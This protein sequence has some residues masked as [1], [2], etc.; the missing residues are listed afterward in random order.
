M[1]HRGL[2]LVDLLKIMM[3]ESPDL[4]ID[5]RLARF[6][7]GG[8][9]LSV[10]HNKVVHEPRAGSVLQV[11]SL[12]E[13]K[14]VKNGKDSIY[15]RTQSGDVSFYRTDPSFDPTEASDDELA[16][17]YEFDQA[18]GNLIPGKN[19]IEAMIASLDTFQ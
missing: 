2:V 3:N 14:S 19:D 1:R 13:V 18:V 10:E 9:E 12:I 15:T 7:I 5:K 6:G 11:P 4:V 8:R 16:M 17:R